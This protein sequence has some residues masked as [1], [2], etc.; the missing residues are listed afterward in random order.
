MVIGKD[1]S[2]STSQGSK[3]RLR[4]V[5]FENPQTLSKQG[6]SLYASKQMPTEA[7]NTTVTQGSYESSNVQ[8]MREL[9]Q[10]IETVRAYTSVSKMIEAAD[11]TRGKA[12]DQ[13]GRLEN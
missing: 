1:G 2:I 9:T 12:I 4:L 13:L 11:E 7:Q 6:T 5:E 8:P 10:M 3:D